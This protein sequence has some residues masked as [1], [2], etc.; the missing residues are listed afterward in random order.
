M[1][2]LRARFICFPSVIPVNKKTEV[3]IF[4]NDPS[5]R[6]V[7]GKEYE[8]FVVGL[9]DDQTDYH[10]PNHKPIDYRIEKGC[11]VF[12]FTFESEQE[13]SVRFAEKG[14]SKTKI[15]VYAL[16]EDLYALRPLKGDFHAHTY[17]SD[18]HDG[19]SMI[20][21][22]YREEGFDFYTLTDHNRMFTSKL[23]HNLF[24]GVPLGIHAVYGEEVH[25]PGSLIHIV[26]AGGNKSVCEQY[27]KNPENYMS[28]IKEIEK[29]LSDISEQ[30][31][32]RAAMAIWTTRKIHEAG[33][34][35]IFVHPFWMPDRYNVSK[36]FCKILF[37]LKIFDAF[38]LLGGIYSKLNNM[39]ITLWH[40]QSLLGNK[41]SLVG[42]SDSHNHDISLGIYARRFT[43]VFA[44]DNTTEAIVEAVKN[45]YC[46]AGELELNNEKQPRFYSNELRFVL[47]AHFLFENYFPETQRLS[48]GEGVLMRRYAR[49]EEVA[50]LLAQF[51]DTVKEFYEK[52]FGLAPSPR[53]TDRVENFLDKCLE[54]QRNGPETKG[55]SLGVYGPNV[56]RE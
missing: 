52:F 18:G 21:A 47:Y 35:A 42:S 11:M 26:H 45:G 28:E 19:I 46:V 55:S 6:F 44:K 38:E 14:E 27:I 8:L 51:K 13:Y 41:L 39:N 5:R 37:D 49:G 2:D 53:L 25:T 54:E 31:R 17:Y 56:R 24:D 32:E 10:H 15:S 4:P 43:Y 1:R 23:S 50:E 12:D 30:Y 36:D 33:G 3:T 16:E 48:F 20:A 9:R 34:L 22:D 40:E 29:E 7:E